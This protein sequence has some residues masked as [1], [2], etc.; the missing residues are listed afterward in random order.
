MAGKFSSHVRG[1]VYGL[2]AIFI[3]LSGTSYAVSQLPKNSV[4]S[5]SAKNETFLSKD[6]KNGAAVGSSDV[7]DN[8]LT[9]TD[10][11]EAQLNIPQQ[12]IP[13]SLPPSGPAGGALTGEYPNPGLG[14]NT[15]SSAQIADN[16]VGNSEIADNAVGNS[17]IADNAVGNSEI[18]DNA[19]NS[20]KVSNNALTVDDLGASSVGADELRTVNVRDSGL[21]TLTAGDTDTA[22]V[23]CQGGEKI[24]SGGVINNSFQTNTVTTR[25]LGTNSW[26]G[27]V[28]NEGTTNT[29]WAVQA[30]CLVP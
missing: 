17:E 19:V 3:A 13:S 15:V 25:Q 12:A 6:L 4:T 20:A 26:F 22:T 7:I 16:A 18:A 27:S 2:I 9:G 8:S 14:N 1:N 11:N 23:S 29:T 10:I 28:R 30:L 5:K 21:R 24:I